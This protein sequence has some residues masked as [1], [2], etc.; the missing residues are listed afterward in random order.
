M[1]KA[2][3][4]ADWYNDG[5]DI[6][7][8]S[9]RLGDGH[10]TIV[11]LVNGWL[12]LNQIVD[13]G[14]DPN[15]TTRKSF[16]FSHLYTGLARPN[17]RR[18]LGLPTDDIAT[19]LELDP[20]S[21][22]HIDHLKTFMSWLYGQKNEPAIIRRQNPDLN[23]LVAVLGNEPARIML[24]TD[25]NLD[26]AYSQ[27]EDKG[28]RFSQALMKTIGQAE[29]A[30][31]F[32]ANYAGRADLMSAGDNLRRTVLSLHRAMRQAKDIAEAGNDTDAD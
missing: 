26:A 15:Q 11:R 14:F 2:K 3:Y 32:V 19:V 1:A 13:K 28:L 7:H 8:I 24:E 31:R 30:A 20:V 18:Y 22:A 6:K 21:E 27:V 23:H 29:E 17:V 9:R 16:P 5:G 4:A 25:R 10:N 12:V